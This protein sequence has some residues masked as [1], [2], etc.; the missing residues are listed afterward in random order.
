MNGI[1]KATIL[2]LDGTGS[3]V[4]AR[5]V[6]GKRLQHHRIAVQRR[7]YVIGTR[8]KSYSRQSITGRDR[9]GQPRSEQQQAAATRLRDDI[10]VVIGR[11]LGSPLLIG[12][13]AVLNAVDSRATHPHATFGALRGLNTWQELPS[14]VAIGRQSISVEQLEDTA[15]AFLAD[16][17]RS[18]FVSMAGHGYVKSNR[19]RRMRDGALSPVVTEIHPD[20]RV[21]EVLEQIREAELVQGVDRLRAVW[22]QRQ[23]VLMNDLCLDLDYDEIRRHRE[24]V[25]GG[26][27]LERAYLATGILPLGARYLHLAHPDR[28]PSENAASKMLRKYCLASKSYSI[29]GQAVLNFRLQGQRG[30]SSRALVDTTRHPDPAAKLAEVL[31]PLTVIEAPEPPP[32]H[33][34]P[35]PEAVRPALE[36]RARQ[37]R[38]IWCRGGSPASG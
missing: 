13:K 14:A 25:L 5:A 34:E 9:F 36:G 26:N 29:W 19:M 7:A 8:G 27:P 32:P 24:L 12:N 37:P 1:N 3:E 17:D 20:V 2:A 6:F 16:D 18:P 33:P 28:F 11:Q 35:A 22:H 38:P 31:G 23:F 4:L 10:N 30:S 15:R 21:Q